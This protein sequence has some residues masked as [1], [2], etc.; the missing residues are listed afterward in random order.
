[1]KPPPAVR[2][3]IAFLRVPKFRERTREDPPLWELSR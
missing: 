3:K 2:P 1:V